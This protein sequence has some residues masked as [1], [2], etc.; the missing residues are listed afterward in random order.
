MRRGLKIFIGVAP[1]IILAAVFEG[2]FTRVTETPDFVRGMF[3]G[4]SL[5][6]MLWYFVWLPWHKA[7]TGAFRQ[8]V[9]DKE[10]PPDRAQAIDFNAIKNAGEVLADTFTVVFRH[11]K[12]TLGVLL[13]ATVLF[14]LWG[15]GLS[16]EGLVQTFIFTS[17]FMGVLSGSADFFGDAPVP[18]LYY[19]Q[20]GLLSMLCVGAFRAL[21]LEMD[22]EQRPLFSRWRVAVAALP[23]ALLMPLFILF[24]RA[25]NGPL[26]WMLG[27]ITYPLLGLWAAVIY[28]EDLNPITALIRMF[29]LLRWGPAFLLGLMTV[30]LCILFFLFLD[31]PVWQ[32]TLQL[33]SWLVPPGGES[34]AVFHTVAT[35]CVA[36]ILL[37]LFFLM[38]VLGGALQYFSCREIADA[39]SLREGIEK[40][41]LTRK[42]R[43][44]ARE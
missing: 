11:P 1:V 42:I 36:S 8:A 33:F 28:Y 21:E 9:H 27:M 40:V 26:A 31:T 3:I 20:I 16:K 15:F 7:R 5:F 14:M 34:M 12:A 32:M 35:T 29:R 18:M 24:L 22:T 30:N 41:A 44:L 38:I 10:L 13:S 23:L 4:T 43:G 39:A 6:F 25:E 19:V 17:Q 2:F 37:Y